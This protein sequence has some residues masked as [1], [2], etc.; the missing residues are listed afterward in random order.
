MRRIA[1]TRRRGLRSGRGVTSL[2]GWTHRPFNS[3]AAT[4]RRP[5]PLAGARRRLGAAMGGIGRGARHCG[6]GAHGVCATNWRRSGPWRGPP[7]LDCE[8]PPCPARRTRAWRRPFADVLV[9]GPCAR[10]RDAGEV[11]KKWRS[12]RDRPFGADGRGL[13]ALAASGCYMQ[14]WRADRVS[15]GPDGHEAPRCSLTLDPSHPA[16][17]RRRRTISA[18]SSTHCSISS[19]KR[20]RSTSLSG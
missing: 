13:A 5:T 17:K 4:T 7:R 18:Y 10:S 2:E 19:R 8:K 6:D 15:D 1:E 16:F 12:T 11:G 14:R 9:G 3:F 20:S